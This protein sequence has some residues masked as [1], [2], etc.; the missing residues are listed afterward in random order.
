MVTGTAN[1]LEALQMA[2]KREKD[3]EAFY[4]QAAQ[5]AEEEGARK[6]YE[7]LAGEERK[8]QRIIQDEIDKNF[9]KEM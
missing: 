5:T 4:L 3:A 2:L 1:P 7:F 6:M 9:L 8:H